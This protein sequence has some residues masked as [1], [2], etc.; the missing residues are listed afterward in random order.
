MGFN[1]S[2][3]LIGAIQRLQRGAHLAPWLIVFGRRPASPPTKGIRI[4]ATSP[5]Q[6]TMLLLEVGAD[7]NA[8]DGPHV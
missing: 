5:C 2:G 1:A 7:M 4:L 3:N 8:K 6:A